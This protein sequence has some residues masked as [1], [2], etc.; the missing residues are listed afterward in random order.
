MFSVC[1]TCASSDIRL[2]VSQ[3]MNSKMVGKKAKERISI[4]V[5]QENKASQFF[6]PRMCAYQGVRNVRF[7][8]NLAGFVFLKHPFWDSPV[9]YILP[10]KMLVD[11]N[12]ILKSSS[13]KFLPSPFN[14]LRVFDHFVV[15]ALKGLKWFELRWNIKPIIYDITQKKHEKNFLFNKQISPWVHCNFLQTKISNTY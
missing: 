4:W 12:I 6:Y 5:F 7:S 8:K 10:T 9:C 3:I 1:L 15:L 14:C 13:F 11:V 2:Q